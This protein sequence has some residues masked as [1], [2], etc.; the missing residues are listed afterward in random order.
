MLKWKVFMLGCLLAMGACKKN[1][2]KDPNLRYFEVGLDNGSPDWRDSSFVVATSNAALLLQIEAQLQLPIAQRKKIVNGSLVKGSGGYNKNS[3]HEFKWHFKE[4]D[5]S[6]TDVSI[7]IYDGR[8]YSD[9]DKDLSYW[10]N[11]VKR[12]S[13]WSSYIKQEIVE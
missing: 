9:V 5:W 6:L 1:A 11:T 8:P 10:L 4:N 3:T 12:F 7:E 2:V 13:P